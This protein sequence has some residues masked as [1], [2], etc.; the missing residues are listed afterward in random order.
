MLPAVTP[1]V[2]EAAPAAIT[3]DGGTVSS[4]LLLA[5]ETVVE[6]PTVCDSVT[7]QVA[8]A[9]LARLVGAQPT[10]LTTIDAARETLAVFEL[11]LYV[12]VTVAV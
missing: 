8:L 12:A 3:V 4:A 1:N 2:P 11:L 10:E 9:P 6:L 7:V 5:S